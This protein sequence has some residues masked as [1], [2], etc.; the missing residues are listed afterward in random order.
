[1]LYIAMFVLGLQWLQLHIFIALSHVSV[2]Y[3]VA[4]R[5]YETTL[6]NFLNIFNEIVGLL[7][8]YFLLPL[9]DMAYDPD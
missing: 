1:M 2:I 9:Q 8:G 3:V 6:L 5:P 7:A 4:V